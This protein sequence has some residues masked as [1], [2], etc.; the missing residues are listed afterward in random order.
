MRDHVT[1]LI[2]SFRRRFLQSSREMHTI[3]PVTEMPRTIEDGRCAY[4]GYQRSALLKFGSLGDQ[5]A[6]DPIYRKAR[7]ASRM[8]GSRSMV[9]E[10]AFLSHFLLI[11][12]FLRDLTSQNIIEFGSYK[13]GSALFLATLLAEFYP[14]A[15]MVSLDTFVGIPKGT[16][17]TDVP[18]PQSFA[19]ANYQTAC[20]NARALGLKNLEF[21][22][23][24][25]QD[26]A[27]DA[28]RSLGS[29]GLA[30]IDVVLYDPSAFAQ[31]LSLKYLVPG[32]YLIQDDA[33]EPTCI[34]A[35]MAAEMLIRDRELSIEQVWPRL[36]FRAGPVRL[37]MEGQPS[38]D[39]LDQANPNTVATSSA[40]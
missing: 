32:G 16:K 30:H 18:A 39:A 24:K 17:G 2:R 10:D 22:P 12:F 27:P 11:K 36:I 28:C 7:A 20:K 29:L 19:S 34:G 13:G 33:L 6:R 1:G 37:P 5:V 25:I 3:P 40:A 21:I 4:D 9:D 38:A 14:S 35:T 23:G 31:D 26:T 15:R 8:P